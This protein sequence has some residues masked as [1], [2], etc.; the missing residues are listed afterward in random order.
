MAMGLPSSDTETQRKCS[1]LLY[2]R[3][4]KASLQETIDNLNYAMGCTADVLDLRDEKQALQEVYDKITAKYNA[5]I[6]RVIN[7]Q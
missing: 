1:C 7:S 3:R 4:A 6:T 2:V 5:Y